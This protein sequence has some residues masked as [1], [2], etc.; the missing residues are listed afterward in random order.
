MA[1][2]QQVPGFRAR[3]HRA[4]ASIEPAGKAQAIP[5]PACGDVSG[6]SILG[7][8]RKKWL[9]FVGLDS[10]TERSGGLV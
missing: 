3:A 1:A 5:K 6:P 9:D 8:D 2:Q 10:R 7:D 4:S